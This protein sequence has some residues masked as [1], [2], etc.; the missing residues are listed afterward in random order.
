MNDTNLRKIADSIQ[1]LSDSIDQY[2][3]MQA[4]VELYKC[5]AISENTFESAMAQFMGR[6]YIWKTPN[7]GNAVIGTGKSD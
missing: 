4:Y 1:R 3:S 6:S 2:T 7:I 5:G